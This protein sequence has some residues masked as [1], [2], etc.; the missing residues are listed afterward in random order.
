MPKRGAATMHD[1]AV[2]F[3]GDA[4][5]QGVNGRRE[6]E[7]AGVRRHVVHPSVG[8]EDRACHAV[9]RHVG[10]RCVERGEQAGAVGLAVGLAGLHHPHLDA[11]NA[12]QALRHRRACGLGLCGAI[13]EILA[14]ALV[15]DDHRHR[16][17]WI[18]VLARERGV[19]QR[20][21]QQR[22]RRGAQQGAPAAR[23][24]HQESDRRRD[25]GGRPH[26]CS[27]DEGRETDTEVHSSAPVLAT[28]G[29]RRRRIV[30]P[31]HLALPLPLPLAGEGRGGAA[32]DLQLAPPPAVARRPFPFP[33]SP[34]AGRG[35]SR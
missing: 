26:V 18:A 6:A 3:V 1:A 13:A 4:A 30:P 31:K 34:Q 35:L 10:E 21:H 2:A 23:D 32:A 14:R 28:S 29:S 5:D 16:G 19:R 20:Q 17:E 15:D 22:Q 12:L 7:R 27:R 8:D 33:P 9:R 11:G 24:Q 25:R